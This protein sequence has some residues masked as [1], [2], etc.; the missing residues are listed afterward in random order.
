MP[1]AQGASSKGRSKQPKLSFAST[2]SS[3][4]S[5]PLSATPSFS[6]TK[7]ASSR[8][9]HSPSPAPLP[10]QHAS[11]K[12]KHKQ[13]EPAAIDP[14]DLGSHQEPTSS[15]WCD[16]H[17]PSSLAELSVHKQKVQDVQGW[18]RDALSG[19]PRL[20]KYRRILVLTGPAGS[21]KTA[22]IKALA[23]PSELDFEILEWNTQ[24]SL[25][26][27]PFASAPNSAERF[28]DFL[29][30]AGRYSSL[31]L[32]AAGPS[33]SQSSSQGRLSSTPQSSQTST[34]R[35]ILVEDLPNVHH[36][37]T[38]AAFNAALELFLAKALPVAS[39]AQG[40]S[41]VVNCPIVLIIS[42]STPREDDERWA[43]ES[44]G[45]G[46]RDRL[47]AIMDARTA[48]DESVRRSPAVSEIR[49][50]PVAPTILLKGLRRIVDLEFPA[51]QSTRSAKSRSRSAATAD[52]P[53][54]RPSMQTVQAVA[55]SGTGDIRAAVNCLQFLCG[56]QT[57]EA[58][59][60]RDAAG[61]R[62]PASR[63]SAKSRL[64]A[65]QLALIS[66]RESSLALFHAVGRVLYNKRFGDP[67]QEAEEQKL[68][69]KAAAATGP[70]LSDDEFDEHEAELS[71]LRERLN[72]AGRAL[73]GVGTSDSEQRK[74]SY[75]MPSHYAPLQR[76][77]SRVDVQ[78]LWTDLP[79]DP[80]M[81]QLYLHQNYTAFTTDIE[82]CCEIA[83]GISDADSIRCTREEY[84]HAALLSH[85]GFLVTV[86][87]TLLHLPSPVPRRN[88]KLGK[89][90]FWE[91]R[92]KTREMDDLVDDAKQY[93]AEGFGGLDPLKRQTSSFGRGAGF[94][95]T[96]D[97]LLDANRSDAGLGQEGHSSL[98][99]AD[100][101]TLATE[102]VPLLVKVQGGAGANEERSRRLPDCF[103]RIARMRFEWAGISD[104]AERNLEEHEIEHRV[105]EPAGEDD[106]GPPPPSSQQRVAMPADE[107]LGGWQPDQV[108]ALTGGEEAEGERLYL[109]D[110][111]IEEYS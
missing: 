16:K 54:G 43:G 27:E 48:L 111:D 69:K 30:R 12:G 78:D 88:Q 65:R 52:E 105:E 60:K 55:D 62:K 26:S 7:P 59:A 42:E 36:Q 93:L 5:R 83:S 9:E 6:F 1:P 23:A 97:D 109:S 51:Q 33:A 64:A 58:G 19:N 84:R 91:V 90:A 4:N 25:T 92:N 80:S 3:A 96:A 31:S 71:A 108:A 8:S 20:A 87:S 56:I 41:E 82:Q 76:R 2:S 11:A 103:A 47:G 75:E 18:L 45:G 53:P 85:Y 94:L 66:G 13:H 110:D 79:V 37:P 34:R 24:T 15:L 81:F 63:T 95:S 57:P 61:R 102:I 50:N 89:A 74:S 44:S 22:T 35:I 101:L 39:P 98:M 46:W 17:S 10:L 21:G 99:R 106:I 38:K 77:E 68:R 104:T 86:Q 67:G 29:A 100:R 73:T 32:S 40:S 49:F 28:S 72:R 14:E 107:G 70:D